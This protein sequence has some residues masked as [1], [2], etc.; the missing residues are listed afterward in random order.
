MRRYLVSALV[1]GLAVTGKSAAGDKGTEITLDGFKS[2]TPAS[3][4]E[5]EAKVPFRLY[6]FTVPKAEGDERDGEVV[7]S[8]TGK[9]SGGDLKPNITRWQEMFLPPKGKTMEEATKI[10]KMKV[11]DVEV[12]VVN[13]E[14]TY[15]EKAKPFD[16]KFTPRSDFRRIHMV[17]ASENGP[18][19]F[20]FVGP[21]KTVAA[22][23][24]SFE[25][26][27]KGFK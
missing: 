19:F 1:L 7:I 27:V 17:F 20:S 12:T 5:K 11:G 26:W 18:F 14:G 10:D 23:K 15:K 8:H 25:K 2:T 22:H 9:G 24:E 13:I 4:K 3:W 16:T 21:A 6:T